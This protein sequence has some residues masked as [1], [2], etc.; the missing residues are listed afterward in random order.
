MKLLMDM[1]SAL[2]RAGFAVEKTVRNVRLT[3]E[4]EVI[5]SFQYKRDLNNWMKE[6]G[7]TADDV[8][9]EEL[10]VH[11]TEEA[12]L[13][14]LYGIIN[15][16]KDKYPDYAPVMYAGGKAQFRYD[17]YPEYKANRIN[18]PKP[19]Y[20]DRLM[21]ELISSGAI[22]PEGIEA[23]DAVS[24]AAQK[25][26]QTGEKYIVAHIDKDLDQIPGNHY[27]YVTGKSYYVDP[28]IADFNFY[29][30]LLT[31]DTSDNIPGLPGCGPVMAGKMLSECED[32]REMY[33]LCKEQ[34]TT[35]HTYRGETYHYT[36]EDMH[37]SA[38]LL[39]L[40]TTEEDEWVP[41]V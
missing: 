32:E 2:Y 37:K 3:N 39:Y 30:Q 1:D 24:I 4:R 12:A 18:I 9:I 10:K 33:T 16:I 27:N 29:T 6:N 7:L 22:V 19:M 34:W 41:P 20:F 8:S 36:L 38:K 23:D 28:Y 5:A 15:S 14:N 21:Q 40:L 26:F 31:G 13:I 25:C 11:D 35:E 17:I